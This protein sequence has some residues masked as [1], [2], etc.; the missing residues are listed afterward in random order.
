MVP[1]ATVEIT[2]PNDLV[3][4]LTA[5]MQ[6][7]FPETAEQDPALAF[8]EITAAYWRTILSEWEQREAERTAQAANVAAI[9]AAKEKVDTDAGGI[10]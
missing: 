3:P 5:A 7:T 10:V 2:V 4:R 8:K 6:G 1:I 9:A